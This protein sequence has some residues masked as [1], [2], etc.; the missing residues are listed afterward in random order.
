MSQHVHN[1]IVL[2]CTDLHH[3]PSST[4]RV[5]Q[6]NQFIKRSSSASAKI[7]LSPPKIGI[8]IDC[9]SSTYSL[10]P[11]GFSVKNETPLNCHQP[12]VSHYRAMAFT[13]R[14]ACVLFEFNCKESRSPDNRSDENQPLVAIFHG[15]VVIVAE[16]SGNLLYRSMVSL[17]A[18]LPPARGESA[19]KF[20]WTFHT[21]VKPQTAPR[22]FVSAKS[23]KHAGITSS[24]L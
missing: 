10:L 3:S 23:T 8:R 22:N 12:G 18:T 17:P 5:N 15:F 20:K 7:K 19:W 2:Y 1:I 14:T 11:Y 16:R 4:T 6:F 21:G 9:T 13:P 24:S